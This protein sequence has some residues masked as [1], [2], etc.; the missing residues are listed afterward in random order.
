MSLIMIDDTHLTEIAHAIRNKK[1]TTTTYTPAEMATAIDSLN[2]YSVGLLEGGLT[3]YAYVGPNYDLT[4]DS[5]ND[6]HKLTGRFTADKALTKINIPYPEYVE[7]NNSAFSRCSNLV[8]ANI[9]G[10]CCIGDSC[11][12]GCSNLTNITLKLDN[13]GSY[14][15]LHFW[16]IGDSAFYGCSKLEQIDLTEN[17]G[18]YT[19]AHHE[20]YD[21]FVW[22]IGEK[23]F[24][25]CLKFKGFIGKDGMFCRRDWDIYEKAFYNCREL[26]FMACRSCQGVEVFYNCYN[27][28]ALYFSESFSVYETTNPVFV[29]CGTKNGGID[30]WLDDVSGDEWVYPY[31]PTAF[32]NTTIKNIYV[33]EHMLEKYQS[34][35]TWA[36]LADK[37]QV[38][39]FSQDAHGIASQY[40][41]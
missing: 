13:Y 3:K 25:D 38:G 16:N 4:E 1:I 26:P 23:A 17:G 11:F 39:D 14:V 30:L 37:I 15:N 28:K 6:I 2:N 27:L 8:T 7:I 31:L 18:A 21:S 5:I 41:D 10:G 35:S 24:Y 20:N 22:G 34:N 40:L 36:A 32:S 9:L 33:P 12:S 19:K 29:N